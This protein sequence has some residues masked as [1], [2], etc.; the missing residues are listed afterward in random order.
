MDYSELF[1]FLSCQSQLTSGPEKLAAFLDVVDI[2]LQDRVLAC[3]CRYDNCNRVADILYNSFNNFLF[4]LLPLSQLSWNVAGKFRKP[5]ISFFLGVF[6][7]N[8]SPRAPVS[9]TVS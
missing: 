1:H 9:L 4:V 3:N 7:N 6:A 5:H 2:P 8:H